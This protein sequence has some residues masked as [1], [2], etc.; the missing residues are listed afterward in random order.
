MWETARKQAGNPAQRAGENKDQQWNGWWE[1]RALASPKVLSR[2]L[3]LF[4]RLRGSLRRGFSLIP[5]GR[6][7]P[8]RRGFSHSPKEERYL[9]AE[10]LSSSLGCTS[11]C[12]CRWFSSL[13]CTSGWGIGRHTGLCTPLL[14]GYREAYWAMYTTVTRV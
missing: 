4:G 6:E 10:R 1:G 5:Q 13:G 11:G 8:L 9:C 7:V 14:T 3:T 2:P 12:V